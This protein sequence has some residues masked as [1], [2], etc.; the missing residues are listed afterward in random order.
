MFTFMY[1]IHLFYHIT[2]RIYEKKKHDSKEVSVFYAFGFSRELKIYAVLGRRGNTRPFRRESSTELKYYWM[3]E[4][5]GLRAVSYVRS[6]NVRFI[7]DL[8]VQTFLLL[9]GIVMDILLWCSK[10]Y[11]VCIVVFVV[12]SF[13]ECENAMWYRF[14]NKIVSVLLLISLLWS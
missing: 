8:K 9:N 4:R 13:V 14:D 11:V 1:I 7:V 2:T 6:Y 5:N 3:R 10:G 12:F